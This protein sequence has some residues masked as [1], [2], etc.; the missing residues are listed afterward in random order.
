MEKIQKRRV[1]SSKRAAT[2]GKRGRVK[3]GSSEAQGVH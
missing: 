2:K 1:I 3:Y